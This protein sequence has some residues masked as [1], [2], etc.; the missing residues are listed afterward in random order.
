[1]NTMTAYWLLFATVLSASVATGRPS[2]GPDLIAKFSSLGPGVRPATR[3]AAGLLNGGPEFGNR[4]MDPLRMGNY[5]GLDCR[6]P[7]LYKVMRRAGVHNIQCDVDQWLNCT[8]QPQS[9]QN[10]SACQIWPGRDGD[11]R[12]YESL[13]RGIVASQV[14]PEV[15]FGV[16]NEPNSVWPGCRNITGGCETPHTQ[17]LEVWKHTVLQIRATDKAA[18]IVGPSIAGFNMAFMAAFVDYSVAN[19]VVPTMLDWHEFGQNGSEIPAHHATMR[20]WLSVHHPALAKIP[21]GHGE[22]ISEPARLMAGHTLGVI[23][24]LE[25]AGA[26]FGV[27]STWGPE[28]RGFLPTG[29]YKHCSFAELVT[30]NDQPGPAV[31]SDSTRLPRATYH[32]YAAYGNTSGVMVPVSRHCNDSDA[33]ASFDDGSGGLKPSSAWLVAGRYEGQPGHTARTLR[34]RLSELPAALVNGRRTSVTLAQIPN[35]MQL[36]VPHPLPMGT[37]LHNV[38]RSADVP[39]AFQLDLEIA[40]FGTHDVWTVRVLRPV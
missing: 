24:G 23:A 15:S 18:T 20:S 32:V 4:F 33:F 27:H 37:T 19:D 1:M 22:T 38:T 40:D 14:G 3:A 9:L 26:A 6:N 21:I 25:R 29:H 39:G 34:V 31:G 36:P 7:R 35:R 11:W 28:V 2:S 30:C 5:R 16:S 12:P 17:W 10:T 13:V 8:A